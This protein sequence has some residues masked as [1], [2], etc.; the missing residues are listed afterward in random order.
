M[1]LIKVDLYFVDTTLK[2]QIDLLTESSNKDYQL[3]EIE[4]D[5]D[6]DVDET[7]TQLVHTSKR[8][9]INLEKPFGTSDEPFS[10]S[11][12]EKR[13]K[14]KQNFPIYV[15]L[16]IDEISF[17]LFLMIQLNIFFVD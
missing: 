2:R 16:M 6:V 17:F 3:D 1:I 14:N 10:S 12:N 13:L 15:A 9:M 11:E 5:E 8:P 4:K 7:T